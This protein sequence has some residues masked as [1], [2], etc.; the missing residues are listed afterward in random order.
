MIG[1]WNT[2]GDKFPVGGYV[3]SDDSRYD[4]D[5]LAGMVGRVAGTR[6]RIVGVRY[7]ADVFARAFPAPHY[8]PFNVPAEFAG[9][10]VTAFDADWLTRVR[11]VRVRY[12]GPGMSPRRSEFLGARIV[13][14]GAR[15]DRTQITV[16]YDHAST[17]PYGDAVSAYAVKRLG[18]VKPM[19]EE[20]SARNGVR[21]Y[22]ITDGGECTCTDEYGPCEF[23][24]E[25]LV[26]REGAS[27]RTADELGVEFLSDTA[28]VLGA[29][30]SEEFERETLRLGNALADNRSEMGTAW[31]RD[32]E[33]GDAL[34]DAIG[35]AES[36][37]SAAGLSAYWEDGYRIIRITGG[38]LAGDA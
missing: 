19:P 5:A 25:T 34:G 1:A 23:H 7:P 38:P 11:Y 4:G 28:A 21:F 9:P 22:A 8:G 29:W 37:L 16:P 33:D 35:Q 20:I 18:M 17:D 13:V 30:P 26:I 27:L 6:G 15:G 12:Y 36:A 32:A 2:A 3:R 24:G 10:R 31:F 14:T